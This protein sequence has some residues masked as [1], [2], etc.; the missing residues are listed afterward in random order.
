MNIIYISCHAA[1]FIYERTSYLTYYMVSAFFYI[2][3]R[4][5]STIE[6]SIHESV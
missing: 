2:T 6:E 4:Y 1:I 5:N 3:T